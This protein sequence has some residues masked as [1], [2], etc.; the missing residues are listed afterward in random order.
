MSAADGVRPSNRSVDR[1]ILAL[2]VPAFATLVSEP[3]LLLADSAI[4]GHLGTTQ[5]AGLGIAG[6]L[7]G[8]LTGLS[9]FLAYGTTGTVARR[10]GAGDK[11]AALAGGIDG[12]ALAVLLGAALCLL[13]QLLLPTV[14]GWYGA[15]PAVATAA[16]HYLRVAACGLP[17][18]LLL[19]ASTGVLRGLQDTKTPLVVAISCNLIN[20]GLNVLLVYGLHLGI[21]GSATGSLIAQTASAVFLSVVV[22]RAARRHGTKI[23]FRPYGILHAARAGFWLMLRT[24]TLQLSITVTTAVA[25]G[26]GAVALA[27]H[28]VVNSLWTFLAFALDALAIAA[29]AVIGRYLGAGNVIMVRRLTGRMIGWGIGAGL[30]FGVI[31]AVARP[32]YDQLFSPDPA[33]QELLF[34]VLLVV[35]CCTPIAGVVFVLDGVLIGA[36]DGRYLALAGLI[37]MLAY[38]PLAIGVHATGAGLVWLWLAFGCFMLARMITLV[39]RARG[40]RWMR[41]GAR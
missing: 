1:E 41:T 23:N 22:I 36:G 24:A 17:S 14:I 5:L 4:I 28:Q 6:N 21:A 19:L 27:T 33:V 20:I 38:L 16:E 26:I 13:L 8:I 25:A 11:Q 40:T 37:A 35:A 9:I 32:L 30:V 12:M 3:A 10:L 7:L 34:R 31:V 39:V 15:G 18:V 2:A 29:Q